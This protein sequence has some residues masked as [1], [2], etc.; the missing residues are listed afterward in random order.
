MTTRSTHFEA[1]GTRWTIDAWATIP[2]SKWV[3]LLKVVHKRIDEFDKTYSRFRA[4]SLVTAMSKAAGRYSMP[5]DGLALFRF[6]QKLYTATD[7]KVTPMIGQT[8]SDAGYDANYSLV[9]K[10]LSQ[11]S[12]WE[13]VI[14]FSAKE[15][16][17]TEPCLLDFGAAGKGYLVDIICE[18]LVEHAVTE[19]V[20]N[21]G[22]DMLHRGKQS[23]DVG[24]E[25]PDNPAE[26]LG[27]I[28]L[29]NQ[30]LC[31]SAGS[32]RR[33][34]QYHHIIDPKTLQSPTHINS[35]WVTAADTMT[36]DGL[37]TALF[38]ADPKTL[39]K[40]FDFNYALL[41]NRGI[42][43]RSKTMPIQVFEASP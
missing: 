43:E 35:V 36:A 28:K 7:G 11:P 41:D 27:I 32:R 37:A 42:L 33:W 26:A 25:N 20:I 17:L 10:P 31:A 18:I 8:I 3:H 1:I 29:H 22:G 40:H 2:T 14:E 16:V 38:F 34:G 6:Y 12:K 9:S 30:S 5:H 24:L 4:D 19:F 15:I 13:D 21:A 23:V 39:R